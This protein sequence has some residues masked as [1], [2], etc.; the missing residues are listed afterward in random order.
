MGCYIVF[1]FFQAE[2]GIR[3]RNV[4]GV[5][6][7]ALPICDDRR[8]FLG[9]EPGFAADK[10][11]LG[12]G[13]VACRAERCGKRLQRSD[14]CHLCKDRAPS[15]GM[16]AGTVACFFTIRAYYGQRRLCLARD[17]ERRSVVCA[18][19]AGERNRCQPL[20]QGGAGYNNSLPDHLWLQ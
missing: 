14:R 18:V 17:S 13:S 4:T 2:D 1:F 6:T 19:L 12:G 9:A 7:C 3:D 10:N 8:R 11:S 16:G 15:G 20:S 5:Q